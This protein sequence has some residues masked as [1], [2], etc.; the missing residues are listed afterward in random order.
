MKILLHIGQSKTGTSAIQD[1]LTLN[2]TRLQKAGV[3]YPMPKAN[4][5]TI[6]VGHHNAVADSLLGVSSYPFLNAEA[7]FDQFYAQCR[8]IG[9]ERMIL[10]GEH[11][12]GGHPRL[13]DVPDDPT[14]W[15]SYRK[16][17]EH[18]ASH[19]R[20]H[21]V[22]ILVYLRPQAD[23]LASV[24]SHNVSFGWVPLKGSVV[25]NL[26][27]SDLQHFNLHKPALRYCTLLDAWSE[28]VSPAAIVAIPYVRN[29]LF[30]GSSIS[31]FVQRAN[32][33]HIDFPIPTT[34]MST[35]ESLT[36]EYVE[37]KKVLNRKP[38]TMSEERAIIDCLKGL[39]RRSELRGGYKLHSEVETAVVAYVAQDN[40]RLSERYM[41]G[42][43]NFAAV[44]ASAASCPKVSE[45]QISTAMARFQ[46][47]YRSAGFQLKVCGAWLRWFLRSH[48]RPLHTV[49]H[50]FK[51]IE[52]RLR[53]G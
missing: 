18:L 11:F 38:K 40:A 2:R 53:H 31:D 37:V 52:R 10:S 42:V 14:Y 24:I 33:A 6:D 9:A 16:K 13:W 36:P 5:L 44:S 26:Y 30:N 17:L 47:Q 39:S 25:T 21:E 20:G 3:V 7:Y 4:G 49:L 8:Q 1:F 27:K 22:S 15:I 51:R 34:Q 35:N 32:L 41:K 28:I 46:D 50:Q 23:W 45:E 19:L 12:W 43:D 48:L 29:Q